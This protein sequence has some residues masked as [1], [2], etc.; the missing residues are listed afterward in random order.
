MNSHNVAQGAA[1]SY[2]RLGELKKAT[3]LLTQLSKAKP[4]DT[5]VRGMACTNA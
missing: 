3:T 4:A 1:V 2:A 5:Q